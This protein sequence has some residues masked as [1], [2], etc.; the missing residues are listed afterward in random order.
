[1]ILHLVD[2]A[3]C[4]VCSSLVSSW[5]R[6]VRAARPRERLPLWGGTH[7][8]KKS[9]NTEFVTAYTPLPHSFTPGPAHSRCAVGL[10]TVEVVGRR[11][12]RACEDFTLH[13]NQ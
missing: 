3:S 1:M 10:R 8:A 11:C 12:S 5:F 6:G 2:L 9:T 4:L 13:Q 7:T